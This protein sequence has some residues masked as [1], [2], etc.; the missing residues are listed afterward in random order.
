MVREDRRGLVARADGPGEPFR[1][2]RMQPG[3]LRPRD[4]L[5]CHLAGDGVFERVFAFALERRP[6]TPS[7][8]VPVLER[9]EVRLASHQLVDRTG[10]EDAADHGRRLESRLLRRREEIEPRRD[11][12]LHR[13]GD[14]DALR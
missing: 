5:V 11:H 7:D 8:E 12:R 9:P 4:A 3:P 2:C 10:P 14:L 1:E 13:I 6:G